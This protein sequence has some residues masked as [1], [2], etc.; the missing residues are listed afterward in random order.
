M[1][2]WMKLDFYVFAYSLIKYSVIIVNVMEKCIQ[3]I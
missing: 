1:N 3:T 2:E